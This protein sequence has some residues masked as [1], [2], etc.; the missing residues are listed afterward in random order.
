MAEKEVERRTLKAGKVAVQESSTALPLNHG[1]IDI[2]RT[3]GQEAYGG[4][5]IAPGQGDTTQRDTTYTEGH[6]AEG[7]HSEGDQPGEDTTQAGPEFAS[8]S[9][10]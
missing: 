4:L 5:Q 3:K 10:A 2:V 6:H 8:S 7:A 9:N 1:A